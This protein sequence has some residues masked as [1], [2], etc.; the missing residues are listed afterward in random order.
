MQLVFFSKNKEAANAALVSLQEP[1]RRVCAPFGHTKTTYATPTNG[2][3][4]APATSVFPPSASAFAK[5]GSAAEPCSYCTKEA[6]SARVISWLQL[7]LTLITRSSAVFPKT[8]LLT[9][10]DTLVNS[11]AGQECPTSVEAWKDVRSTILGYKDV[12]FSLAA[13]V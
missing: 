7:R 13:V 2:F 3:A 4:F 1:P 6:H 8:E 11:T 12:V 5:A 9:F 10:I